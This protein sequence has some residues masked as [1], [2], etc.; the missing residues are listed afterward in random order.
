MSGAQ[1]AALLRRLEQAIT[2]Q[3]SPFFTAAAPPIDPA[4]LDQAQEQVGVVF[5]DELRQWWLWHDGSVP[6][7]GRMAAHLIGVGG[8]WPLSL[9]RA[10]AEREY[11]LKSRI[12]DAVWWPDTW[13]PLAQVAQVKWLNADLEASTPDRLVL[14]VA[15]LDGLTFGD[16]VRLTFPELIEQWISFL[17]ARYAWWDAAN[18]CWQHVLPCPPGYERSLVIP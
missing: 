3:G 2:A 12:P 10:L 5:P 15:E 18:D 14:T 6:W 13:F 1:V 8:Y 11:W 7:R 9:D 16:E 17:D 4:R